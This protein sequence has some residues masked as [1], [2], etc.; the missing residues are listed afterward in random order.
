MLMAAF[1]AW[2]VVVG[3]NMAQ[4]K[5][6]TTVQ[7]PE[8]KVQSGTKVRNG[9]IGAGVGAGLGIGTWLL[10][11]TLGLATGGWGL[12]IGLGAM[13]AAGAGA[14]AV[15]GA[16]TGKSTTTMT[17]IHTTQ[18]VAALYS[19]LAWGSIVI[20][21]VVI[22]FYGAIELRKGIAEIASR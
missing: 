1:G 14:G 21:G 15:A 9:G 18:Q 10:V 17:V 16:A 3:I 22:S 8:T 11:G 20:A 7:T 2:L 13:T 12:A 19:P 5:K 6:E 4:A